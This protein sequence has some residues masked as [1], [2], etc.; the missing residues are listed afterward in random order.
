MAGWV[1]AAG[2]TPLAISVHPPHTL[3]TLGVEAVPFS[4]LA[5]IIEAMA[6]ADLF[7][8]GGGGLFQDYDGLDTAALGRFP[9]L[10]ATQYAQFFHLALALGL[11]TVALAQGIGPLRSSGA[12]TV[13]ADVFRR[14]D[15]VSLRDVE[16]ATLLRDIGVTR[17]APVAPDPVWIA[18]EGLPRVN[19]HERFPQFRGK[20]ILG[21]NVRHWPFDT[22][23]EDSFV[24]AF[25]GAVPDDWGCL[26]IDFQRTPA[27]D[28]P[29]FVDDEIAPRMLERL[30]DHGVHLRWDGHAVADGAAALAACDAVLAMRLH[31]VLIGHGAGRPVVA[32]EYDGKVRVLGDELGVPTAQRLP[33]S[34]IPG[35]LRSA[36]Q[37]VTNAGQ[38]PFVLSRSACA[39]TVLR[40]LDH[41]QVLWNA[42][43][44][45]M[46]ADT[47][48]PPEMPPLL[49]DWLRQEP[50]AASRALAAFAR[51]RTGEKCSVGH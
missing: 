30:G 20:R 23:W 42:M 37:S 47:R 18:I 27:P 39:D 14:A 9:A 29:G 34:E 44:M 41:R 32:L 11:P 49:H 3:A 7:V 12:R 48:Q 8:L 51:L 36:I 6:S 22:G 45:A 33:L 2:G 10:N 19:L 43:S 26:W 5:S 28:G 21:V 46:R 35:R 4:D 1:R 17:V 24:A 25:R 16:S 38:Q 50:A 15:H 31:G 13:T 40:A